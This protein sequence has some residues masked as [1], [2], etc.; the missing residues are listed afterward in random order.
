M[1]LVHPTQFVCPARIR[2]IEVATGLMASVRAGRVVL[3][4]RP[5]MRERVVTLRRSGDDPAP[6][7]A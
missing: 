6:P 5:P 3:V 4:Q 1:I 7:A 2:Q